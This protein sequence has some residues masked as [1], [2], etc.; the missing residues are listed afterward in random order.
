[1]FELLVD[2]QVVPRFLGSGLKLEHVASMQFNIRKCNNNSNVVDEA[3]L[4]LMLTLS[5]ESC[6]LHTFV[7]SRIVSRWSVYMPCSVRRKR[8]TCVQ[9]HNVAQYEQYS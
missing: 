7:S 6:A 1:V 9:T 8:L 2:R 4:G 3:S 5:G